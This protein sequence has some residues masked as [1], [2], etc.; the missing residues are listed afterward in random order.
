M[1]IR[2]K[3]PT[4]RE[5]VIPLQIRQMIKQDSE[6]RLPQEACGVLYGQVTSKQII[7]E[8][9]F[10]L[11]NVASTP[12]RTFSLDP[13]EWV[14]C[15]FHSGLIGIYHSHPTSSSLP[16]ATDLRD[17]QHY[18]AMISLYLIGAFT[19][20]TKPP[21]NPDGFIL[22]GYHVQRLDNGTFILQEALCSM[23]D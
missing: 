1:N 9:Y 12:L 21:G 3:Y 18:G 2:Q 17:L 7:V 11:R 19:Q 15:C 8:R 5:W 23:I 4:N 13:E 16:S 20:H 6:C 22:S 14:Q 10:P